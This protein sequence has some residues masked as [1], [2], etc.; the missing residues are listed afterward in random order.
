MSYVAVGDSYAA[1]VGAG[2]PD[3]ACGRTSAGYPMT[4]SRALELPLRYEACQGATA[5]EAERLQAD[6][7][8]ADTS[9]VTV[10]A[11][12]NDLDFTDVL[13]EVAK[14]AWL[15]D[16]GPILDRTEERIDS[17]LPEV[18][19]S[20]YSTLQSRAPLARIVV[21]GYPA[22]FSDGDCSLVTFFSDVEIDRLNAFATRI[23]E[24]MKAA[25][26]EADIEFIDVRDDFADHGTC[27][28]DE[29]IHGVSWPLDDSF[30]PSAEGH[31]AY[32]RA[33]LS[34]F[35]QL[36][37]VPTGRPQPTVSRG[38]TPT[39]RHPIF[40]PPDLTSQ[41]SVETASSWGLDPD[42]VADLGRRIRLTVP[43][44][45]PDPEAAQ[46]LKELHQQVRVR[47]GWA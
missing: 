28:D 36:Q 1:G 18:L 31:A 8:A 21:L 19:T 40:A 6:A 43:G 10:T 3:D 13:T 39:R 29:W 11:G 4:V 37:P 32:A 14:P 41:E 17:A 30:H 5:V 42:L 33:A 45:E 26:A 22:L 23:A 12:G 2:T 47:R 16:T 15:A 7:V 46:E 38:T 9:L 24:V 27:S 34:T 44:A 25:C 20:L 35:D